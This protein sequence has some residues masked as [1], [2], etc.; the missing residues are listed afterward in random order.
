MSVQPSSG[1]KRD[2]E[3]SF[4]T[5]K[6]IETAV[7]KNVLFSNLDKEQLSKIVAEMYKREV[8]EGET[9]IKQGESGD[10][11]YVVHSGKFEIFVTKEGQTN[12]VANR[13]PKTSFGELALMYNSPRAA[14]VTAKNQCSRLGGGSVCLQKILMKVSEHKL[15]EYEHFLSKVPLLSTLFRTN[16]QRSPKHWKK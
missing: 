7:R 16:E 4:S 14:T 15:K 2:R 11:F 8:K 3:K 13:G 1:R 9:I 5:A 10:N 12:M 6:L